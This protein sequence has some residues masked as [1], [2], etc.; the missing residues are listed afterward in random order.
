MAT[1]QDII[2]DMKANPESYIEASYDMVND[3]ANRLQLALS[4]MNM[5]A[6]P[7]R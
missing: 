6:D 4:A 1:I 2:D 3:L 5:H 7:A